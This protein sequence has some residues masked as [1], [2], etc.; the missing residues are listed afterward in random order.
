MVMNKM[1]LK[2]DEQDLDDNVLILRLKK[3]QM[4]DIYLKMKMH[5]SNYDVNNYREIY[6][7]VIKWNVDFAR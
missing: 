4:K 7:K 1:L 2:N 6:L 3:R 5:V